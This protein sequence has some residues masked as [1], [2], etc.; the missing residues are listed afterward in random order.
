MESLEAAL[1]AFHNTDNFADGASMAVNLGEDSD[2]TGAVYGQIAGAYYGASR[3]PRQ[4]L[5]SLA[6]RDL[7]IDFADR[8]YDSRPF[9]ISGL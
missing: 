4:W 5:N 1:W 8:L 2:T 3:I 7:I 6:H 9:S